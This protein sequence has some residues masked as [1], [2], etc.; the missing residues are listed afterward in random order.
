LLDL[1][2]QVN[3]KQDLNDSQINT[4]TTL[5]FLINNIPHWCITTNFTTTTNENIPVLLW[6]VIKEIPESDIQE[7]F[8]YQSINN[9]PLQFVIYWLIYKDIITDLNWYISKHV[10]QQIFIDLDW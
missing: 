3:Q 8:S 5:L 2:Q 9:A 1:L 10:S 7:H 6:N 4:L